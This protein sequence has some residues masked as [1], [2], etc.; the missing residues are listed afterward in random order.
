MDGHPRRRPRRPGVDRL[1]LGHHQ[2]SQGRHPQPSDAR[3]R[4][5][6][7]AGELPAR[8]RPP[9][10]RH[11][12]RSLHRHA[13]RLP[14]SGARRRAHRSVR[15]VGSGPGARADRARRACRS[16]ADRP[17]FVT[18]VL[19]HPDCTA[20]HL[21]HFTT[22]GL[23]GSTVPA[24]VTRRLA[25]LGMFVFRSYGSTEHPSITGSS[26]TA[27]EDKRLL[28]RR[29][30]PARRGDPARTRRRDLQPRPRSVPGLHRSGADRARPSTRT[31]GTAPATSACSTRTAISPSPTARPTSSSAAARTSARS[32]SRR[33]CSAMPAVAEAVVVAAPDARLGERAAAVLRLQPGHG[34]A[35]ARRGARR[36]SSGPAS[37]RQKWPEELH[38]GRRLS[39][40]R[41]RQG[42]EV[43]GP[44]RILP[45]RPLQH[46]R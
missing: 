45:S 33:C 17:Y 38:R 3:L 8:P 6:P 15:R 23:G 36:T 44:R 5:A 35:D 18:S 34:D 43:P 28:H 2:Q 9:A 21:R 30:R 16:A 31:A 20:E 25:D 37:P 41:E 29:Q 27:P 4:D 13:R 22:V 14:D 39:A 7:A 40:H 46:A 42:A 10:H 26:P 11:P 12:G 32:R 19:D 1:H 24:A